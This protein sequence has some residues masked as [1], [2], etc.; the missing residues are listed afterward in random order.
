MFSQ[1]D[2]WSDELLDGTHLS[3][4]TLLRHA[5]LTWVYK[6]KYIYTLL[7]F[8]FRFLFVLLYIVQSGRMP[9]SRN[10]ESV[11]LLRL[12]PV[13]D[14]GVRHFFLPRSLHF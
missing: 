7:S 2:H 3:Y 1:F 9:G 5:G 8:S 12:S 14:V 10:S 13:D 11:G 6:Y 4:S